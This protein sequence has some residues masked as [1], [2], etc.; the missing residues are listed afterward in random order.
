MYTCKLAKYFLFM[1][2]I[3]ITLCEATAPPKSYI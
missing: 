1:K 3:F 2:D